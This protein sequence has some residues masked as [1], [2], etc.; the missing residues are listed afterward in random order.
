MA[1]VNTTSDC[2]Q[3][4]DLSIADEEI[5]EVWLDAYNEVLSIG[6]FCEDARTIADQAVEDYIEGLTNG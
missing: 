4:L 3:T 1:K 6:D 2:T 5:K